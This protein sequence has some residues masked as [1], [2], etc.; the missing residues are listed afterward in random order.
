VS[1]LRQVLPTEG[2]HCDFAP[3][4]EL[5]IGILRFL[6]QRYPDHVSVERVLSGDGLVSLAEALSQ[7]TGDPLDASVAEA[8][9]RDRATA[10]AA[11]T[12]AARTDPTCRRA[13]ET[14][15][16]VYGA[17]AGNLALK[18]LATAGVYVAGGIAPRILDFLEDGRFR[19]AFLSKGRMRPLLETVPVRV[20][21]D[22]DAAVR[23]AAALAAS[24]ATLPREA[25]R[26]FPT[27]PEAP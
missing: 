19:E 12:A 9:G 1:G 16:S 14:F 2:G 13:V 18:T 24:E 21:L 17:E 15:C 25:R 22:S 3:R 7:M 6:S 27:T 4:N 11:V 10:P 20:V 8:I 23:G 26:T 5:E